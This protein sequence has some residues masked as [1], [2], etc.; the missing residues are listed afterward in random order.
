MKKIDFSKQRILIVDDQKPFLALLRGVLSSAGAQTQ[1]I[2]TATSCEAALTR[3]RKEK[4]DF[5]IC[6]LHLGLNKKNGFEFL[7]ELRAKSLLKPSSV[8]VIISAD[9]QRPMVLGSLEKQPDEYVVK[10]F[11]QAQL[12]LRLEKA[13]ARKQA[14]APVYKNIYAKNFP[15]AIEV[16]KQ[17]IATDNRYKELV[18]RLL[19]ELY[20][21]TKQYSDAQQWLNSYSE[22]HKRTWL[23]VSKAQTEL[24]LKNYETAI[25][26]ANSALRKNKLLIE[27]H[28]IIAQSWFELG[29]ITE[30]EV[31][32]NTALRLSPFS[33]ERQFKACIY[34][35]KN[36]NYEKI[37][38]L[39]Q[40]IWEYSK[41]SVNR[42][43]SHLCA[44]VR[45]YL[46]VAQ[47]TSDTKA[48]GRFQQEALYTLQRYRH[49]ES[50]SRRD[51]FDFDV[52]EEL[53]KARIHS[54]NGKLLNSKQ[55][56][57][58]VQNSVTEKFTDFPLP[59]TPDS[60]VAML[61][62]GEFEDAQI[63][64]DSLRASG[65]NL[66]CNTTALLKDA[67]A[68]NTTQQDYYYKFNQQ[69]IT[70]HSQGKFEAAYHAFSEAQKSAPF[71]IGITLNLLQC[72]LRLLQKTTKPDRTLLDSSKKIF[73]LVQNMTMLDKHQQKFQLLTVELEKFMEL[74]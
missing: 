32:I 45:S 53:I 16:C 21:N 31:A 36:E 42:D 34:A 1:A 23:T 52:F 41:K 7:E 64:V 12:I 73:R 17:V 28:D 39:S 22:N 25:E 63:L 47:H 11:S 70:Y 6:D 44:H 54:Q 55:C 50:I 60:I 15:M 46:E 2:V 51:D 13:Y 43:L 30:A 38:G 49:N 14:L 19:A 62:L 26:L 67:K 65:K 29:K 61:D 10:P 8:F 59:L 69:G 48:K 9:S 71:N 3:C 35:R 18:G 4:F 20:W 57:T 66:D 72:S 27:A 68:R 40:S 56:M 74:K 24:L 33:I 58:Q 5:I 37:I